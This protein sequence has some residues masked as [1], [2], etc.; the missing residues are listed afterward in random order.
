MDVNDD[1]YQIVLDKYLNKRRQ[2]EQNEVLV[3]GEELASEQMREL[4]KE[5]ISSETV[6]SDLLSL[7]RCHEMHFK[8]FLIL[9][10]ILPM[11]FILDQDK[12]MTMNPVRER[13]DMS[14]L[15]A[16]SPKLSNK[17]AF[18]ANKQM[19]R[20]IEKRDKIRRARLNQFA[21]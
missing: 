13:I 20:A 14:T 12:K 19:Q 4:E 21:Q 11:I 10:K 8:D 18:K 5:M 15:N 6:V 3:K 9:Q 2:N 16:D 7:N 17:K 1:Y